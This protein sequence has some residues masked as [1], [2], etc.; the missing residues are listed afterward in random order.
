MNT[1]ALAMSLKGKGIDTSDATATAEDIAVGKTAYANGEK[2]TGTLVQN[3]E[4]VEGTDFTG[5]GSKAGVISSIKKVNIPDNVTSIGNYAFNYCTSLESIIIPDSVTSIGG[6][7]FDYCI[8]LKSITIPDSVTS[9]GG[10]VFENCFNLES[11][12]IP[13]NIKRFEFRL[14]YGCKKL[15]HI[16]YAG[17]EQQWN[18]IT[19]GDM[20]NYNMG[21]DVSG[22]TKIHYN[23]V[24]E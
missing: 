10:Y 15:A 6:S 3:V 9:I 22:G 11:I 14:F 2:L 20:W 4:F 13:D 21:L 23:Y 8:S 12:T 18:S 24:P 17:T 7:A 16:Y 19:K 5:T 1:I